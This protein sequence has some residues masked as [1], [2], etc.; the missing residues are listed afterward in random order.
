MINAIIVAGPED[1]QN[2]AMFVVHDT[3]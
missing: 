3:R 2:D 1:T